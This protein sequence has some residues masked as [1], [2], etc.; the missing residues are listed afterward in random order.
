LVNISRVSDI[1]VVLCAF[2]GSSNP[3]GPAGR[4]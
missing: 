4:P 2:M 3:S 1:R